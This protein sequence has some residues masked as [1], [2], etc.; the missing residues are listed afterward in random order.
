[1]LIFITR[2]GGAVVGKAAITD[3]QS[4]PGGHESGS[5]RLHLFGQ[6]D[7]PHMKLILALLAGLA[8]AIYILLLSEGPSLLDIINL[9]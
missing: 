8:L 5:R 4:R 6:C 9:H 2:C 7:G 3:K 1:M